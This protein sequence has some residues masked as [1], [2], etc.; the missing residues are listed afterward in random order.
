MLVLGGEKK[1]EQLFSKTF[2][3][4]QRCTITLLQ[5]NTSNRRAGKKAC[6]VSVKLPLT[7]SATKCFTSY[8]MKVTG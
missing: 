3:A 7:A 4:K 5:S 1:F 6:S 8:T 2:P